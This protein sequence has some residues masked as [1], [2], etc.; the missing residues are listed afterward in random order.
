MTSGENPRRRPNR[1]SES[2]RRASGRAGSTSSKAGNKT[3]GEWIWLIVGMGVVLLAGV[4]FLLLSN[5]GADETEAGIDA[6]V[7]NTAASTEAPVGESTTNENSVQRSLAL[8]ILSLGGRVTVLEAGGAAKE[9]YQ[10]DALPAG[11]FEIDAVRLDGV[12]AASDA[13]VTPLAAL[14]AMRELGLSKT[15]VTDAGLESLQKAASL[16]SLNLRGCAISDQGLLTLSKMSGL[17]MIVA[18]GGVSGMS[19]VRD[20]GLNNATQPEE[21]TS[22]SGLALSDRGIEALA[23]LKGLE[24]LS[25]ISSQAG[26][27]SLAAIAKASRKLVQLRTVGFGITDGG[28]AA[29]KN[30]TNL[31]VLELSN[32]MITDS[33]I[34][35]LSQLKWLEYLVVQ[36]TQITPDGV[37]RLQ[38]RLPTCKVFGGQY[39]PRLNIIRE[40]LVLGGKV[41]VIPEGK[42]PTELESFKDLPERF[43]VQNIDLHEVRQLWLDDLAIPEVTELILTDSGVSPASIRRLPQLFPNLIELDLAGTAISDR[44]AIALADCPKLANADLTRTGV[45]DL[46]GK[47]LEQK[48][49][50]ADVF[51]G[52]LPPSPDVEAAKWILEI[53]GRIIADEKGKSWRFIDKIADLPVGRFRVRQIDAV[54]NSHMNDQN[55]QRLAGLR[56]L[57]QIYIQGH[58]FTDAGIAVLETMPKLSHLQLAV[59]ANDGLTDKALPSLRRIPRL[60]ALDLSKNRAITVDGIREFGRHD[61]LVSINLN[62]MGIT[63]DVATV[64]AEQFPNLTM[65]SVVD[66]TIGDAGLEQIAKLKKLQTLHVHV[67]HLYDYAEGSKRAGE[68]VTDRGILAI[69]TL[70]ELENLGVSGIRITNK[71]LEIL[72]QLP[73]LKSLALSFTSVSDAGVKTLIE[74]K[75]LTAVDLRKSGVTVRGVKQLS[76]ARPD[77]RITEPTHMVWLRGMLQTGAKVTVATNSRKGIVVFT[78]DD[79]PNADFIVQVVDYNNHEGDLS[80]PYPHTSDT[81]VIEMRLANAKKFHGESLF[82]IAHCQSL[83]ILDLTNTNV[84]DEHLKFLHGVKTLQRVNLTGTRCTA[85]G[86]AALKTALP[87]CEVTGP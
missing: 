36:G 34:D 25:L 22:S 42:E 7:N 83:Q 78:L 70:P 65:L 47:E 56:Y 43:T 17:K 24:T 80:L 37:K 16:S 86:I 29:L 62:W 58:S 2:S 53:G 14:Q 75:S 51:W 8:R 12:D 81:D 50:T 28:V 3:G 77:I 40:V 19:T 32:S 18:D 79:L 46:G 68:R 11:D 39:D 27:S 41:A 30:L 26:D 67:Q 74:M 5:R 33:C 10:A 45:T 85:S 57:K 49:P 87:Q 9:V 61:E 44:E 35:T 52:I 73:R 20:F 82:G 21:P 84:V 76:E 23:A 6:V 55:I 48:L 66:S 54:L 59:P 15:K 72:K 13:D 38:E 4:L 1:L 69:A 31:R 60:R 71:E 64:I 63:D